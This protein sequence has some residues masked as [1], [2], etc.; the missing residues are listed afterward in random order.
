MQVFYLRICGFITPHHIMD[1]KDYKQHDLREHIYELPGMYIGSVDPSPIETYVFNDA[2]QRMTKTIVNYVPGLLKIYDEILTN[3]QDSAMRLKAAGAEHQVKNIKIEVNKE[4]GTIS[5]FNDGNGIPIEQHPEYGIYVPELVFGKL[6]TSANYDKNQ[7]RLVA[8]THGIGAKATNI[9]S[10]RFE[11]EVVDHKSQKKYKQVFHDNMKKTDPPHITKCSKNPYVHV[12]F[13]PDYERFG[14]TG[15]TDDMFALLRKRAMD[16]CATTDAGVSVVF[17]GE[18]LPFKS[19][20]GYADLFLGPKADY[21]RVHEAVGDR[22]EVIATYSETACFEHVSFVNGITTLRGGKHVDYITNQITKKLSEITSAKKKKEVKA[23]HLRDNLMVFVKCL[24]VNPTFDSQTKETLTSPVSKFGSKCELS[25]KFF[26]KLYKTGLCDKAVSLTEFHEVKKLTKTDGKK[27]ARVLVPKL[28]DAQLAGTKESEQT[29]LIVTEGDSARSLAISGLSVIGREKYGVFPLKGKI[30]NVKDETSARIAAND[31][32][33]ALKKILGLENGKEYDTLS[34]LRYGQ[35]MVMCDADH[36]GSHIKGLLF[37]FFQTLWPSLLQKEG[38]LVSLQTP[39]MKVT[40]TSKTSGEPSIQ[41][42]YTLNDFEAWLDARNGDTRGYKMVYLKGLGSSTETDA[43]EYFSSMK[44]MTYTYTPELSD[45]ALDLAFNKKRSDDRKEWLKRYNREI[46]IPHT[47]EKVP[48]EEFIHK[49]LIHFSNRD[50]ER[51]IGHLA[52]GLKESQRKIL[53]ACFK[54]RLFTNEIKVAQ[55]GGYVSETSAYHHGEQ[56]LFGAIIGMAQNFTGA[57]NMPLLVPEGQFGT[58]LSG[59]AD[60]ASPRYIFTRLSELARL[61]F[62]EDDF[63][64]I[65]YLEDDGTQIQPEYYV[66]VIPLVLANGMQG[67]ATGFATS[68]P[69][70]NPMELIDICSAIADAIDTHVGVRCDVVTDED[71][72]RAYEAINNMEIGDIRP[73]YL[74]YKGSITKAKPGVYTSKGQY[75]FTNDTTISVTELPIGVWTDSFKEKLE[76]KLTKGSTI[77]KDFEN[78]STTKNVRFNLILYPDARDKI[79][80][81]VDTEFGLATT[82]NLSTNNIN[83][84]GESGTIQKFDKVQDVIKAWARIRI[85]TYRN[86]KAYQLCELQREH[87][88]LSAK[89]RFISAIIDGSLNVMNR[90]ENDLVEELS[91]ADPPYPSFASCNSEDDGAGNFSYLT[92]MPIRQLTKQR[93]LALEDEATKVAKQIEDLIETPITLIWIQE[94]EALRKAWIAYSEDILSEIEA[95]AIG[96]KKPTKGTKRRTTAAKQPKK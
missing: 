12:T 29:T 92:R 65:K 60:A 42:F 54:R 6:L 22:W 32:I 55:L 87:A 30:L 50:V 44:K 2:T 19:F 25:D 59:G 78:H 94:L 18:K 3:A 47:Q 31:E 26:D 28:D 79:E 86:R 35:I 39:I 52:D 14:L 17:N 72:E 75:E 71:L 34:S 63:A 43:K 56:S 73:W 89:V 91:S 80:K 16:A 37:N 24:I 83:L 9:F 64:V 84:F 45:D 70:H 85:R 61:L 67:I 88:I 68:I 27:T 20:E 95:D 93:K 48:Y 90:D 5:I 40:R 58:R 38:F 66:P 13:V 7:E 10:K 21:P 15:M 62:R 36:D 33:A 53:Y 77:L 57:N 76:E 8:G 82:K 23:Q 1:A 41:Y 49:D 74:G 4:T 11:I 69:N 81:K 96:T 46:T 51:S